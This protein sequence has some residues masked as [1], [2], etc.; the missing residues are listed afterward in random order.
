MWQTILVQAILPVAITVIGGWI[1]KGLAD[2]AKRQKE[3]NDREGAVMIAEIA[4]GRL[5]PLADE[6]KAASSDGK[7]TRTERE[8]LRRGAT[9]AAMDMATG[10]E[11]RFLVKMSFEAVG[12][13]IE[14][15][16]SKRK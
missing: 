14:S 4:A 15:V 16:L 9:D 12:G 8:S 3:K 2:M 13:L 7:L 6:L 10:P 11:G 1:A 5:Q